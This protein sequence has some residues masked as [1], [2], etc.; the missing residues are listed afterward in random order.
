MTYI[1]EASFRCEKCDQTFTEP[2]YFL[3]HIDKPSPE[4]TNRPLDIVKRKHYVEFH[5][6]CRDCDKNI[7]P[8]EPYIITDGGVD[9]V[10]CKE[11]AKKLTPK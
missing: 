4:E 2:V 6:H 10:L 3:S 11:C 5:T 9:I 7:K 1:W 8:S